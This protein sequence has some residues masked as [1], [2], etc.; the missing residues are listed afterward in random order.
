MTI[1]QITDEQVEF[2]I[3][4]GDFGTDILQKSKNVAIILTQGW[5]GQWIVMRRYLKKIEKEKNELTRELSVF[6]LEYNKL[7]NFREFMQFKEEKLGNSLV[8]YIQYY[9][10]GKLTESSNFVNQIEFLSLLKAT[11]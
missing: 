9:N 5:C 6:T 11:K 4:N 3:K 10:K 2:A 8:P 1:T 7:S